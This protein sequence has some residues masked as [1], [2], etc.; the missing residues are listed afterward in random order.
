M[1]TG[2]TDILKLGVIS[3]WNGFS[4]T[5]YFPGACGDVNGTSGEL[6][7][8]VEDDEKVYIFAPDICRLALA[9]FYAFL[10]QVHFVFS[11]IPMSLHGTDT[12][13]GLDG[14]KFVCTA[15]VFDNG[16]KYPNMECF[17]SNVPSGTRNVS[18]CK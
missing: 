17:N 6:W 7:P 11:S 3:R 4:R 16:T 1:Y 14:K 10:F 5:N 9:L 18:L 12:I 8:P 15:E 2:E 13:H